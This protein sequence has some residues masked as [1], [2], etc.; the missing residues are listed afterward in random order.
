MEESPVW[1]RTL[2]NNQ[3]DR[4]ASLVNGRTEN[5]QKALESLLSVDIAGRD[6]SFARNYYSFFLLNEPCLCEKLLKGQ[7]TGS[8][9]L[10]PI[11]GRGKVGEASRMSFNGEKSSI[12]IKSIKGAEVKNY[13]STVIEVYNDVNKPLLATYWKNHPFKAIV[14]GTATLPVVVAC[15]TDDFT[16]QTIQ[17]LLLN[18]ILGSVGNNNY[19]YQYDAFY[20]QQSDQ[21]WTGYNVTDLAN[22]GDLSGYLDTVPVN[23]QLVDTIMQQ[24]LTP[25]RILKDPEYSFVHGDLKAKNIFVAGTRDAP[26]FKIA[27]YDKASITWRGMRF[28]NRGGKVVE[29]SRQLAGYTIGYEPSQADGYYILPSVPLTSIA[30]RHTPVPFYGSYDLYSFIYSL[31][32]EPKIWAWYVT[33]TDCPFK[34]T[35]VQL[36]G[37][38]YDS[39]VSYLDALHRKYSEDPTPERLAKMRSITEMNGTFHKQGWRLLMDVNFVYNLYAIKKYTIPA[40]P[41]SFYDPP[42]VLST[43]GKPCLNSCDTWKYQVEPQGFIREEDFLPLGDTNYVSA[44]L[45]P[46]EISACRTYPYSR[47]N[48]EYTW[49]YC[50]K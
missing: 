28:Y 18:L 22:L 6:W 8:F 14:D 47:L 31:L 32:V 42:F 10:G 2:N 45:A 36:W 38:D 33:A 29:A 39:L 21:T 15:H 35:V 34:Q 40:M 17:H 41:D 43:L 23:C 19:I 37:K 44:Y 9:S 16:N 46:G 11:L 24:V 1:C 25:L 20:C 49:D 50:K 7:P 26:I 3:Y 30:L 27:D 13:L 12:V 48:R 4:L 5:R